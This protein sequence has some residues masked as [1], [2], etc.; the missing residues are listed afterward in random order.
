MNLTEEVEHILLAIVVRMGEWERGRTFLLAER[1]SP[2]APT[3]GADTQQGFLA[4]Y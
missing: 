2:F 4:P 1:Y 3:Q